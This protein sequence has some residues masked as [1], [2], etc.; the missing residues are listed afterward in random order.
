V[1]S[2]Y[3]GSGPV[4]VSHVHNNPVT[5]QTAVG[6]W[7]CAQCIA[8]GRTG[9]LTYASDGGTIGDAGDYTQTEIPPERLEA[10]L[11]S[12]PSADGDPGRRPP[13]RKARRAAERDAR[14]GQRRTG[15]AR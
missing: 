1:V 13:G 2:S 5:G 7:P 4:P 9:P 6:S 11:A 10:Y 8:L 12:F 14:R 15:G 3:D